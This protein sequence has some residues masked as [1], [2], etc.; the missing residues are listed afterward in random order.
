[1]AELVL[2]YRPCCDLPRRLLVS[3]GL[4]EA[5]ELWHGS[6]LERGKGKGRSLSLQGVRSGLRKAPTAVLSLQP[7]VV[8]LTPWPHERLERRSRVHWKAL[9]EMSSKSLSYLHAHCVCGTWRWP[10]YACARVWCAPGSGRG[11]GDGKLLLTAQLPFLLL[12]G[13]SLG[14]SSRSSSRCRTYTGRDRDA[15]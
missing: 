5:V 13:P 15:A 12:L 3:W 6:A 1:M 10:V 4:S 7:L 8:S 2:V 14:G 9:F 11:R